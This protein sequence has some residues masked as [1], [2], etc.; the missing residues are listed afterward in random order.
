M[1]PSNR[2]LVIPLAAAA[3]L[4]PCA[5]AA[6]AST[7]EHVED[8][9]D[10]SRVIRVAE[11]L[12]D[13]PLYLH[14]STPKQ[15]D[16]AEL[17]ELS[18]LVAE[19]LPEDTPLYVVFQPSVASDETGGRPTL[20]LHALYEQTGADGVYVA[21]TDDHRL[22]TAAFGSAL[23]PQID[24]RQALP[25]VRLGPKRAVETLIDQ[26]AESPRV[27]VAATELV[28][29]PEPGH[30]FTTVTPARP[31]PR[32]W[33][34]ASFGFAVGLFTA[35]IL[36]AVPLRVR[37][38]LARIRV[39]WI[40]RAVESLRRRSG[41]RIHSSSGVTAARVP[42]RLWRWRLRPLLT[43]E[44]GIL[45]HR[46]ESAPTD[47]PGLGRA[48]EAYDAAGLIALSP[49]LPPTALVCA[50]VLVRH[51]ERALE[52]PEEP[53]LSPCQINPLHGTAP[54]RSRLTLGG[55]GR[56]WELCDRC[57][58]RES[59][60]AQTLIVRAPAH[61]R[62]RGLSTFRFFLFGPSYVYFRDYDDVW[63]KNTFSIKDPFGR[64]RREIGV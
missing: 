30:D 22:A 31:G 14:P 60:V 40:Q 1:S 52:H 24:T 8:I 17:E 5:A 20:F 27:H 38:R 26:L 32:W 54:H 46:I 48:R 37:R 29:D 39:P 33:G 4:W 64:A 7:P 57:Q 47:S 21:I 10:L 44:L 56:I 62:G 51:G 25:R 41:G 63:A 43:R 61:R 34:D 13:D 23:T 53:Y 45:R 9:S 3:L 35:L 19:G 50:V 28:R 36:L 59:G 16:Q 2:A 15:P 55:R 58:R 6:S 49:K 42:N 18:A 11:S 12:E